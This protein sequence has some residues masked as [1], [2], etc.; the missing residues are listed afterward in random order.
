MKLIK[1]KQVKALY[2]ACKRVSDY[3]LYLSEAQKAGGGVRKFYRG[4]KCFKFALIGVCWHA[5]AG[6][7]LN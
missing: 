4:K 7:G 3:H 5:E 2:R 1:W 6:G